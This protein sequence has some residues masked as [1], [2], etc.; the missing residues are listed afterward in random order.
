MVRIFLLLILFCSTTIT[1]TAQAKRDSL[2]EL[3]SPTKASLLSAAL[4]GAGQFYN[5]KYWKIPVIYAG[6]TALTYFVVS[7]NK[8][9]K[10]YKEAYKFRLDQDESTT[11]NYVGIYSDE[12]L[13]TLKNYYRRNR[14]LSVI[15]ISI[16]YVLN[17]VDAAVDAHLFYFDVKEDLSF[18]VTPGYNYGLA[19]GPTLGLNI[20]F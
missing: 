15:G 10:T 9:Y 3:H 4:P 6:F 13:A 12:D 18:Q 17:I 1:V 7:N 5:K 19:N 2:S 16:L 8:D 11:D 14:D 20:K